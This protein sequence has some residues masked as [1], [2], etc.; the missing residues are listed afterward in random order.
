MGKKRVYNFFM[1]NDGEDEPIHHPKLVHE[2][3]HVRH[4]V[5]NFVF[6]L[7]RIIGKGPNITNLINIDDNQFLLPIA[8]NFTL[9]NL[10]ELAD[11]GKVVKLMD[12]YEEVEEASCPYCDT[13]FDAGDGDMVYAEIFYGKSTVYRINLANMAHMVVFHNAAID[14][15]LMSYIARLFAQSVECETPLEDMDQDSLIRMIR[16]QRVTIGNLETTVSEQADYIQALRMQVARLPEEEDDANGNGDTAEQDELVMGM[17]VL[18]G[19]IPEEEEDNDGA[20]AEEEE[21]EEDKATESGPD[22]EEEEEEDYEEEEEGNG[23]D[24]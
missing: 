3:P 4:M 8:H 24:E 12:E 22:S 23:E 15:V 5:M 13:R 6:E 11:D 14:P 10:F 7:A 1:F 2:Y 17:G 19:D 9:D 18:T 21:E 16:E 20:G